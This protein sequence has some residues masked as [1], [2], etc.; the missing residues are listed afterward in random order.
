MNATSEDG[1]RAAGAEK[2]APK[3]ESAEWHWNRPTRSDQAP[4][5]DAVQVNDP[6]VGGDPPPEEETSQSD[7]QHQTGG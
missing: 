7:D 3:E 1:D 2:R 4:G 5:E 6:Y